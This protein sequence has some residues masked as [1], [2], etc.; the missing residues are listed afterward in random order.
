MF[1]S[2]VAAQ[3]NKRLKLAAR[4]DLENESFFSAPQLERDPLA[5][6]PQEV[7]S[8]QLPDSFPHS[9]C[10]LPQQRAQ[11]HLALRG[12]SQTTVATLSSRPTGM[13]R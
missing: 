12:S 6:A 4:V 11:R 5:G 13:G 10:W 7:C 3:P 8:C 2:R 1:G 9:P